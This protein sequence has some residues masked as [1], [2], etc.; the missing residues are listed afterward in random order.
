MNRKSD[1]PSELSLPQILKSANG[2]WKI[3]I[4]K[5]YYNFF[6]IVLAG[7]SANNIVDANLSLLR[8]RIAQV[9]MKE[10]THA[11]DMKNVVGT[12]RLD[13]MTRTRDVYF[14]VQSFEF[15]ALVGSSLGLVFLTGTIFIFLFSL[16]IHV[17]GSNK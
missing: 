12:I 15:A 2:S 11:L 4:L 16:V 3:T 14:L 1:P 5:K 17:M 7:N 8:Q 9:R 13:V 6:L 10:N